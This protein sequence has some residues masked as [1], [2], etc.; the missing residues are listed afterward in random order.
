M[1][2]LNAVP[3]NL[4]ESLDN[5]EVLLQDSLWR[6]SEG[7]KNESKIYLGNEGLGL[8]LT[9]LSN[10]KKALSLENLI[11]DLDFNNCFRFMSD[12]RTGV[13][14]LY[15]HIIDYTYLWTDVQKLLWEESK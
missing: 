15:E 13:G 12:I 11:S 7:S 10:L 6:L 9:D 1:N 4:D 5:F 8:L 3:A 14:T 2:N